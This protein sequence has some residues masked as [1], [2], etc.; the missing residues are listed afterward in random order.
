MI[1]IERISN[2]LL[3]AGNDWADKNAAADA[4]ERVQKSIEGKCFLEHTG[5]IEERRAQARND[6]EYEEIA[7]KAEKA[8][9]LALKAKVKYD[10]MK[11]KVE[12]IRSVESTR[13][14]EM[15]FV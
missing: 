10:T 9:M 7:E 2:E 1:D 14:A 3:K 12:L 13:R 6:P 11:T 5:N 4:W 8:R 15:K